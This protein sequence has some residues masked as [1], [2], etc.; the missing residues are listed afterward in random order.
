MTDEY[1]TVKQSLTLKK[2]INRSKFLAHVQEIN[3]EAEARAFLL[4]IREQHRQATH[5]CFAFRLGLPPEDLT[6]CDDDGEPGGSAGKPILGAI[7]SKNVTNTAIV[8]TRYFGGRK[9]GIRGLIEAYGG[10]SKEVLDLAGTVTRILEEK[11]NLTCQYDSLDRVMYLVDKY[12]ARITNS[13]YAEKAVLTLAVR[14]SLRDDLLEEL[15][16][17]AEIGN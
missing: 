6:F 4:H 7:L 12:G 5:N 16:R 17:W 3:N 10:V 9:L 15:G 13:Q 14:R 1:L 11:V 2:V 8:V